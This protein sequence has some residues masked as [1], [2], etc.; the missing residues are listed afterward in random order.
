MSKRKTK[1][2]DFI[3][4]AFY[5]G[6]VEAMKKFILDNLVYPPEAAANK[7]E[8]TVSCSVSHQS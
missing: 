2:S 4:K 6:G 8:G 1:G 7:V 3:Q 5:K